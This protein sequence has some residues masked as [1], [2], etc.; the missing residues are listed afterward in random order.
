LP[1][2]NKV[3][4]LTRLRLRTSA[5]SVIVYIVLSAVL[6]NFSR[7]GK[8][9]R[10]ADT[11]KKGECEMEYEAK[12]SADKKWY[13]VNV[14]EFAANGK[15]KVE[16]TSTGFISW[17]EVEN[18]RPTQRPPDRLRRSAVRILS[19]AIITFCR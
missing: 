8:N 5:I 18:I 10:W 17:V 6:L 19:P 3:L 16:W 11:L 1:P 13:P 2:P 12:D 4:H 9:N 15:A 14:L 7:A